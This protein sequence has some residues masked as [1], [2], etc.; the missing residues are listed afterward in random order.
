MT[1]LL[2]RELTDKIIR[3]YYDVYNG[4]SHTHPEYI[5][6]NAMMRDLGRHRIK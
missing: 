6:E 4:L 3:V 2:Y 1:K 5:Y